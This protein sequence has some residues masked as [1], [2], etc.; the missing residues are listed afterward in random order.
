MM[1]PKGAAIPCNLQH[2]AS[3]V[4][5]GRSFMHRLYDL[6]ASIAKP[7][8]HI[9]LSAG[10]SRNLVGRTA[11]RLGSRE[12]K[13]IEHCHPRIGSHRGG[14]CSLGQALARHVSVVQV[15]QPGGCPSL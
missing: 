1:H 7:H 11:D 2:A 3:V 13:A 10:I 14:C 5:L 8:Q 4:R 6:Q 12:G 9:R 15:R